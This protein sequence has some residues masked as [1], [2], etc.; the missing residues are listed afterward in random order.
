VTGPAAMTV[1]YTSIH[2]TTILLQIH[3]WV[4]ESAAESGTVF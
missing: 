1:K 3:P 4:E 2:T